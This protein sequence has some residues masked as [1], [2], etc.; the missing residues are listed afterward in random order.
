MTEYIETDVLIVGGGPVGLLIAYSLAR[1]GVDSLLVEQHDKHQ[2]AMYGRATTLFPRTLE[3]LD[4]LDLLE[5]LNQIGYI[6]RNSV[7][8][9]DGKRVTSRGWHVMF[10]RMSG[11]F[12]DYCLN[13]RQKYSEEVIQGAYKRLGGEPYVGWKLE[14]YAV[15]QDGAG[16][17]EY[18]VKAKIR[19][20]CTGKVSTVRSKYIVGADGSQSLVRRLANIPFEGDR[21]EFKWVRIDG[22]FETDMPD[23]DM[24]FASIESP[25]HGNVLWVQLDHGVKR[26]GFATTEEMLAKYGGKLTEEQ[27]KHEAIE[28]M[29]PFKLDIKSVEWWTLYSINQRVADTFYNN[30]RILLAGDACHTHSSGAAQG[31]NTGVHDAVNLSW[32]LG[33]MIKGWYT[34]DLL[35]TYDSERRQT[36]Q[37]LIELDK[38]F[39][40]TMS[41]RVPDSHKA[42][43]TDANE[44]L[45]K[46]FDETIQ[47]NIGLGIYYPENIINRAPS[48]GMV[49]AGWRA[50]DALLYAPGSRL[51]TRLFH[52]TKNFG[53]WSIIVFAG[54]PAVTH[55]VLAPAVEQLGEIAKIFPTNMTRF[56]TLVAQSAAEGDMMFNLPKIGNV[57]YDQDRSAHSAYSI[58]TMNGGVVV[59]RPDGLLGHAAPLGDLDGV[60]FFFE[61]FIQ[62]DA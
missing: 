47:F 58:S 20:G 46:L 61:R 44:L 7:T 28:S 39:S 5:E 18:Q 62:V 17:D 57:Y 42:S 27:A 34:P 33:G 56:L 40:A 38:A 35:R 51:P 14:E 2:Q 48:S 9:K 59:L 26:I 16:G 31:M 19:E 25:S 41:G 21:T 37:K 53:Q 1:Q 8:Y 60:A 36:A 55:N 6:G 30:D 15:D 29:K 50:P 11:T 23:A 4:Q 22:Y 45:T 32:K 49:S 54:Q 43:Y 12:L 3:M 13:I 10:E 52:R 24:G